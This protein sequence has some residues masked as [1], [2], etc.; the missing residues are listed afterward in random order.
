MKVFKATDMELFSFKIKDIE[1]I[2]IKIDKQTIGKS[3]INYRSS[4]KIQVIIWNS[5]FFGSLFLYI[6][7]ITLQRLS[8]FLSSETNI[9]LVL[10]S[11]FYVFKDC[12]KQP[13][14]DLF[15]IWVLKTWRPSTLFKR[16]SNTSVFLG[17]LRNF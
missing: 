16:D 12:T 7:D 3:W 10:W 2:L 1:S 6:S 14:A 9:S 8:L 13:F 4:Q 11:S 15:K 5:L 17:I